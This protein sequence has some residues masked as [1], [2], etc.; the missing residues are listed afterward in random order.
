MSYIV[1][2][3]SNPSIYVLC[4]VTMLTIPHTK[5]YVILLHM[6]ICIYV[7]LYLMSTY[8]TATSYDDIMLMLILAY[9]TIVDP[10]DG[11]R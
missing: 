10:L 7:L 2:L 1:I 5:C 6:C 11:Q 9:I 8:G 3:Y 4:Y